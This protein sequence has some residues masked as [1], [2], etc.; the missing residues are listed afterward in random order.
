MRLA[1]L[2]RLI[3]NTSSSARISLKTVVDLYQ[4]FISARLKSRLGCSPNREQ[5]LISLWNL[6]PNFPCSSH[7][8]VQMS[9]EVSVCSTHSRKILVKHGL[10]AKRCNV[11]V[12]QNTRKNIRTTTWTD[13]EIWTVVSLLFRINIEIFDYTCILIPTTIKWNS[14]CLYPRT[15]KLARYPFQ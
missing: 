14:S 1:A 8:E 4:K 11:E 9:R 13:S 6:D 5:S 12:R 10:K 7:G 3:R 15:Y 2:I